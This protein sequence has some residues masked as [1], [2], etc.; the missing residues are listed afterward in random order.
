[1]DS[2]PITNIASIS[3]N[4]K[5]SD[6]AFYSVEIKPNQ[7]KLEISVHSKDSIMNEKY[8]ISLTLEELYKQNKYFKQFD[9]VDEI[10]QDLTEIEN[11]NE[12]TEITIERDMLKFF[13]TLPK[14]GKSNPNKRLE[15][16]IKG[17]KMSEND[18]L[19]RLCEKVKEIDVL[20]RKND[21][22]FHVLG[23]TEKDFEIYEKAKELFPNLTGN[24]EDSKV[25]QCDD[26]FVVQEGILKKLN[27]KIKDIKLLYRASR[28]NDN[29]NTFHSK[30]NGIPNT[31]TFVKA[32][33]G[34]RFGGFTEKGWNSNNN[35]Y[36][37][38]NTFLFS[39]DSKECYYY[40]S[41]NCMYGHSSYGTNWGAG[42][43]LCICNNC[44]SNN[45]CSCQSSFE[46]NG[47]TN[48]L[49]G[50]SNFQTEDYEVYQITLG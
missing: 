45:S 23:K 35:W 19:F 44:L 1:M 24:I 36:V 7:S 15:L 30:C 16:M 14:I 12:L 5:G 40:K 8:K 21:Y 4:C 17:E 33:N 26:L 20:K 22:L 41:G 47:K 43:D 39:L 50:S 49:S 2:A 3:Y 46:Y 25:I 34:R 11:I 13:L 10:F 32:K 37:D 38:N 48:C 27:K 31:V 9:S 28:D 6:K 18:I 42:N 29:V